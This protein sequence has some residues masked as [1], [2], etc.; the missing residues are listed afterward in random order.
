MKTKALLHKCLILAMFPLGA[1]SSSTSTTSGG[2][3]AAAAGLVVSG[4]V[5]TSLDGASV[6]IDYKGGTVVATVNHKLA[7]EAENLTCVTEFDMSF[8]KR[9]KL[10]VGSAVQ[11]RQCR[12]GTRQGAV[13]RDKNGG[14]CRRWF[15]GALQ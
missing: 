12:S 6:S 5:A 10:P 2:T 13:L 11:A 15:I 1:C 4:P 14:R 7:T 3:A 8:A 9:R